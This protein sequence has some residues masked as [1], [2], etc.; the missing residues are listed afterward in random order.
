MCQNAGEEKETEKSHKSSAQ[1]FEPAR[2]IFGSQRENWRK[3][4][5]LPHCQPACL[6]HFM[7]CSAHDNW[8]I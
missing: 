6:V 2:A 1:K 3:G 8:K 5:E 4:L 7:R